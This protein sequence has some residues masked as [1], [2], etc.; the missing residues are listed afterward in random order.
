MLIRTGNGNWPMRLGN[1]MIA[2]H[3]SPT[4]F[5]R[6]PEKEDLH[7]GMLPLKYSVHQD[8]RLLRQPPQLIILAPF[9]HCRL[10]VIYVPHVHRRKPKAFKL[11]NSP[12]VYTHAHTQHHN[13]QTHQTYIKLHFTYAVFTYTYTV[14]TF[15]AGVKG[16]SKRGLRTYVY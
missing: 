5:E 6:R 8:K 4:L 10:K 1:F 2:S 3:C 15:E 12:Y 11:N 7:I 13:A 9:D 14:C 16:T